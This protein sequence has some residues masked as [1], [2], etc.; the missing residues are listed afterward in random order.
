MA[1]E[2]KSLSEREVRELTKQVPGLPTLY[3][4]HARVAAGYFDIRLF[5]GNGTVTATGEP[6]FL[7]ELCIVMTPEFAQIF[8]ALF[9]GQLGPYEKLYGPIRK[10]PTS[11]PT[12]SK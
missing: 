12:D 11:I 3:F 1:D 2:I 5:F 10:P 7:E 9:A 8:L 4:N 6:S